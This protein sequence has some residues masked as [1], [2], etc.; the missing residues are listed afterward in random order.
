MDMCGFSNNRSGSVDFAFGIDQVERIE[1][2]AA[3]VAL[4]SSGV[5]VVTYWAL[6]FNEPV[7]KETV[8]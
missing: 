3:F 1:E 7:C 2:I 8:V 5:F 6:P 4:I